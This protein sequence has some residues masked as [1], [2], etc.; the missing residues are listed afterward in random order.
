MLKNIKELWN[1]FKKIEVGEDKMP[2]KQDKI[3]TYMILLDPTPLCALTIL[4]VF[5]CL[6][7]YGVYH[8]AIKVYP[9]IIKIIENRSR[10]KWQ[11]DDN[12]DLNI[13]FNK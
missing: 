12:L 2:S 11:A 8:L 10:K 13:L 5:L 1:K 6:I 9:L 4:I 7:F 3:L